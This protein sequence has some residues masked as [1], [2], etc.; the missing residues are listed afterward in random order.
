[1]ALLA[2]I[3]CI[4][5]VL[6][7]LT[8]DHKSSPNNSLALWLPTIWILLIAGK[9]LGVWFPSQGTDGEMG[10]P[11]DRNFVII[12]IISGLLTLFRRKFAF[13][14]AVKNNSLLMFLAA[15]MLL[16]TLWSDVF[17]T[18]FQRWI[19]EIMTAVIMSFLIVSE[20]NPREAML[21][22]LRRTTYIAIPFSLLLI[23][24]YPLLGV[25]Y[26]RWEGELMWVGVSTQKNGLGLLCLVAGFFLSWSL[27]RRWQNHNIRTAGYQMIAEIFLIILSLILLKGP[28]IYAMSATSATALAVGL[29]IFIILLL[30][31]KFKIYPG[32]NT[33]SVIII[34]G[35]IF[36]TL[37]V[38]TSG[39]TVG[40]LTSSVGRD[41]TLTGRTE[42]WEQYL[43][44]A[45][46]HPLLGHG[47]GGFWTAEIINY[48]GVNEVHNGY[49]EVILHTGFIGLI[50]VSLFLLSSGHRAQRIMKGDFYWASLWLCFLLI[51]IFH[52]IC[53]S[54][55][56]TFS[57]ITTAILV[58]LYVASS[59]IIKDK[60]KF[61]TDHTI[62]R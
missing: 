56:E 48:Q 35:I 49:L 57:R 13:Y 32:A 37:T 5:F 7:L 51:I 3:S 62:E 23:K 12:L 34:A 22:I 38:F 1:M 10:S 26:S 31:N 16:S 39:Q 33:I 45:M 36:G 44:M 11:L 29:T 4:V 27:I 18:S 54:S 40:S 2:L 20:N 53:E 17:F 30:I 28:S 58:F 41:S 15:F 43:P 24:Y 19:R 59:S 9:P 47:F 55:L 52:N 42:I 25:Q 46:Q 6:W 8:L 21:S 61:N 14:K 50:F 60:K